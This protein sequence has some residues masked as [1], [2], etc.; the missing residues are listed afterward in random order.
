MSPRRF[1]LAH[2]VRP[3]GT[4]L[5]GS[6]ITWKLNRAATVRLTFQR[7]V[8]SGRHR[9]WVT[10]GTVSRAARAGTG[11]VRFTGRFGS[12]MLP[13]RQYRVAVT[14][15]SGGTTAGPKRVT[16]TVVAG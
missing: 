9:R 1:A 5:D 4:R 13:P 8:G 3:K 15:R 2:R 10:V 6:R 14:A 12:R 11:T 7:A 16:F